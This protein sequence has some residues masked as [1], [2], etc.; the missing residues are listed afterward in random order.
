MDKPMAGKWRI[1]SN[2]QA[3]ELFKKD[4][5]ALQVRH[6]NDPLKKWFPVAMPFPGRIDFANEF[7]LYRV[8]R[9]AP[10]Q[11][12]KTKSVTVWVNVYD[13]VPLLSHAFKTK[14]AADRNCSG[15]WSHAPRLGNRAHK[16]VIPIEEKE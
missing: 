4:T 12:R 13:G 2:D 10:K 16:L 6:M 15:A 11:K 9:V 1:V 5:Y 7:N 14:K 3:R 8:R